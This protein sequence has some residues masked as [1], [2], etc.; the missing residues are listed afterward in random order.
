MDLLDVKLLRDLRALKSQAL[1]VALVMA[2]GLAMMIMT[3][4]LIRSL[5]TARDGYYEKHHFAQVFAGL[6]RAPDSVRDRIAALPGVA[7]VETTVEVRV[8]LDLPHLLEP[9]SGLIN[10]IPDR[11]DL[12]L[13]QLFLRRGHFLDTARRHEILV[14]EAFAEAN[15]LEPG[16]R[17]AA[18]LNGS[19]L[20][21]RVAG[22]VLAPQYV[23]EA[24]PGAALPDNRTFGIFWMR[25]QEIAEAFNLEGAFNTVALTLAP[26]A[27]ASQVIAD[28]DRLLEPYGGLGAYDRSEHPSD[29]RVSDEI[30]VLEG[31]SFG[32][33]LVF[34]SVAAF[35]TH[36]VMSRQIALQREQIAILKAFGFTH[37]TIAWHFVKF[38]LV[39]VVL[40]TVLGTTGGFLFGL[41][42]VD[43]Y[44]LFFRFPRLDFVPATN[45][46]LGAL[47]AS[48]AAALVGVAGA[49]RK[50]VRLS[51]AEAMRPEPPASYRPA[52]AERLGI[53]RWFSVTLRMSLRNLERK[54]WQ[55]F[56][57][58]IALAMATGILIIPNA[59]RDGIRH[60]LDFQWDVVQRQTVSVSLVEPGPLR[61][62][63]DFAQL[64]G[65]V[66]TEPF[67]SVA[68]ELQSGH[69]SRRLGI[70]GLVRGAQLNRVIGTD[71]KSL[72]LPA[73][74]L[75]ISAALGESLDI[76][77]GEK[78]TVNVLQGKRRSIDVTV[79]A[80]AEDFAGIAAYMELGAL[81]RLLGEGDR[82]SGAYLTVKKRDWPAFLS[83]LKATP[84]AS[85]VV[86]KEAMR[87]S[88]RDT[89]AESIGMIQVLYSTFAT[90]VAFGIVYNSARIA[91]SERARELA[92]LRVLGFSQSDVG[93][94]L[95][96]ELVV[97]AALAVPLGLWLGSG[98]AST[99]IESINTETVRLPLIL[100]AS[101]YAYA[102]L[103]ITLATVVSATI[104]CRKLNQLDL[105]GALKARE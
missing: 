57:T 18:I 49:V 53:S 44:H 52:L 51:P 5:D 23:F 65:V 75:I 99:L 15:T 81:N 14:S 55:A 59:F 83:E 25:N 92:T 34:L 89:T 45:A 42:L 21:L 100:S 63:H 66:H 1:A 26:G 61:V 102:T 4:S 9:A 67:R 88:F 98:M 32:F 7:A 39:I 82:I 79:A 80:F 90:V 93:S 2:C 31:L 56:F 35:M 85:G 10:S 103:V 43:M 30:R 78:V 105:V 8:T 94:V 76:R 19:R 86:I 28:L 64:P 6:K 11:R 46:I 101:N 74:G 62:T 20:D 16:D 71:G 12:V 96:G 60:I 84:Q 22:I 41:Q 37:R 33:P 24:P 13:N 50:V 40:G 27:S 48:S 95:V 36:S 17:I 104:A 29:I 73:A 69:V 72:V 58:T 77:P 87:Q 68:V 70:K 3:R 38:A 47:L 54:P 91:L 97:L